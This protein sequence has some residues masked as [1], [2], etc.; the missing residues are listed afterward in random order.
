MPRTLFIGDVHSCA[1]ELSELLDRA[2]LASGDQVVFT[3]DL[4]SRG[5][6]PHQVLELYRAVGG[7]APV[8]NH[9]QRL[10]D[11]RRARAQGEKGPRL[12]ASHKTIVDELSDA[13]WALLEAMPLFVDVP[14]HA[15]VVAHAGI[16]PSLPLTKQDPWVV[17]HV[18]SIDKEGKVSEKWGTSWAA[19]YTGPPHIVFGHNAQKSPQLHPFATGL[20][21]GCVYGGRLTGM[22]LPAGAEPPPVKDR[23]DCLI[24]V[25]ARAEYAEYGRGLPE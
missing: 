24:F 16:D 23:G 18:R 25:A 2:A 11:A 10:L 9:E 15:I 5:P 13:D 20:D 7:R 6:K 14:E 22:L 8:G 1:D 21:T 4:L 3:G 19:S 17:T 12:G